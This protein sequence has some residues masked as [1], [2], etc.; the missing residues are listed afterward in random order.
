MAA[1]D[2]R[3]K[4]G[5]WQE[6]M[7]IPLAGRTLG[8]LG[9]GRLGAECAFTGKLGFGMNII[10]WSTSLTQEKADEVAEKRG[11]PKG[12]FRV[13]SSKEELFREADVLSVHY[14]LSD[15]SRGIVGEKE[16][17]VMKKDA[18]LVNT[19][20]GP[21][22]D[23]AALLS[24]LREGRIRGAGLDVYDVEPL[25]KDSPWRSQEW[26]SRVVLSPHT[27][28]VEDETMNQ[29]YVQHADHIRRWV[30]GE[31]AVNLLKKKGQ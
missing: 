25:P 28:Y 23:E 21:L 19:S 17:S 14:V 2:K 9:L 1:D 16:L 29:W 15:R 18:F 30:K 5:G 22:V 10:T 7:S 6:G 13:T 24:A 11:L 20:R 26:G 4:E 27:G 8:L 3:V 12:S 31:E